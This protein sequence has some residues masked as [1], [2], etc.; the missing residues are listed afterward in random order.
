MLS[1]E[2]GNEGRRVKFKLERELKIFIVLG[3][4]MI[5]NN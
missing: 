3:I 5:E 2:S 4:K 1:W